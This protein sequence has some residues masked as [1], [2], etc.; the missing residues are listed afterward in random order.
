MTFVTTIEKFRHSWSES[1]KLKKVLLLQS[2]DLSLKEEIILTTLGIFK[3]LRQKEK[4][5]YILVSKLLVIDLRNYGL[6]CQDTWDNLI[7]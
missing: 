3:N 2:W 6:S 5:L 4:D 7:P 1:S